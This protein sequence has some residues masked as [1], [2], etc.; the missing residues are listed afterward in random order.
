[1]GRGVP[2]VENE[3]DDAETPNPI[4]R[5]SPSFRELNKVSRRPGF[6]VSPAPAVAP[7]WRLEP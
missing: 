6:C 2:F 3:V 7:W 4:A 1:M 5:P